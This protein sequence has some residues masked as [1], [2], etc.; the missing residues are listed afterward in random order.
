M[1]LYLGPTVS[2][3]GRL[4]S[5]HKTFM[6]TSDISTPANIFAF[7]DVTTQNLC[8][9]AFIVY[10][11]DVQADTFFHI[12]MTHHDNTGALAFADGHAE[13]HRWRDPRTYRDA[14]AG[15]KIGHDVYSPKNADLAWIQERTTVLK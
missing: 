6:K 12:P 3:N 7:Q 4:S 8:T 10:M 14:A 11:P 5:R 13:P 1:N 2:M 15:V 9:P